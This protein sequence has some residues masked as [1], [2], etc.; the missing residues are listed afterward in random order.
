MS[1]NFHNEDSYIFLHL[2]LISICIRQNS[3]DVSSSLS[4]Q[5]VPNLGTAVKGFYR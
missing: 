4:N 5:T 1:L 2:E 3:K